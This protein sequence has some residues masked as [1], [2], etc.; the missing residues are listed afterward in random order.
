MLVRK[1]TLQHYKQ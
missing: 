1:I